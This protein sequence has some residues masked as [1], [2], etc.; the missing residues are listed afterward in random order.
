VADSALSNQYEDA[1]E[2]WRES[3]GSC[4]RCGAPLRANCGRK[5]CY[6]C[7]YVRPRRKREGKGKRH[8]K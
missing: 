8:G 1:D 7:G 4:P 6:E 5:M 3:Y 2:K